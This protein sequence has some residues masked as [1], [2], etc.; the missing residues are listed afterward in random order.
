METE[1]G[2]FRGVRVLART[3]GSQPGWL[4]LLSLPQEMIVLGSGPLYPPDLLL[5]LGILFTVFDFLSWFQEDSLIKD[6]KAKLPWLP[7]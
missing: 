1:A 4:L 2:R 5:L 7:A 3:W 6:M